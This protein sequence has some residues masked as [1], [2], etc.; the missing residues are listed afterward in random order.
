KEDP[1]SVDERWALVFAGY[2]FASRNGGAPAAEA[3]P[4][5]RVSDLVDAYRNFGHLA[6]DL[7]PLGHS[8]RSHPFLELERFGFTGD[9]LPRPVPPGTFRGLADVRLSELLEAVQQTY[10]G[11]LA[12][13]LV[14]IRDKTQREWL[15]DRMEN[16]RNQPNLEPQDRVRVLEQLIAAE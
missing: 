5:L 14:D 4:V 9:D 3:G 10:C 13:E 1:A 7:D 15:V 12:V 6:A 8:P 16:C 2:E 11:T